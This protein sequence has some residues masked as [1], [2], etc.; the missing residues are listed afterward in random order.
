MQRRPAV[1]A[2]A[3][4]LLL[5]PALAQKVGQPAPDLTWQLTLNF[6][7]VKHEKLSDLRGSAVFIEF[8]GTH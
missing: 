4:A 3:A 5:G 8:W 2:L 6:G 7:K 1:G